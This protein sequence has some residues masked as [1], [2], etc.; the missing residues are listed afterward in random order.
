M[1]PMLTRRQTLQVCGAGVVGSA[2]PFIS[3]R[4]L[5]AANSSK[6]AESVL[7]VH[8]SGGPSQLDTVDMKPD[9][10]AEIRP[11]K[12]HCRRPTGGSRTLIP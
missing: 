8:L 6:T 5:Q 11:E 4:Q 3:P 1:L 2:L 12:F 10:A 9:A 7:I